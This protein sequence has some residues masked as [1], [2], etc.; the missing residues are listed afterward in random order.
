MKPKGFRLNL[1]KM[2]TSIKTGIIELL[3]KVMDMDNTTFQKNEETLHDCIASILSQVTESDQTMS[4]GW[5]HSYFDQ[6]TLVPDAEFHVPIVATCLKTC[7]AHPL[8]HGWD[9]MFYSMAHFVRK[10]PPST[11]KACKRRIVEGCVSVLCIPDLPQ[12]T[13]CTAIECFSACCIIS[14]DSECPLPALPNISILSKQPQEMIFSQIAKFHVSVVGPLICNLSAQK[15][16]IHNNSI[17]IWLVEYCIACINNQVAVHDALLNLHDCILFGHHSLG[18]RS[19]AIATVI[20]LLQRSVV[21]ARKGDVHISGLIY[22]ILVLVCTVRPSLYMYLLPFMSQ[23]SPSEHQWNC[24]PRSLQW[25]PKLTCDL[26][27]TGSLYH[28]TRIVRQ[29]HSYT[30][31]RN[32]VESKPTLADA[33][34]DLVRSKS[35]LVI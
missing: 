13:Q 4:L 26:C 5:M 18:S 14:Y 15:L 35:D 33:I 19:T 25:R 3:G 22:D 21:D 29:T 28:R 23:L 11:A 30:Y 31:C 34:S 16:D 1:P 7:E 17:W 9:K 24:L 20:V 32:M 10:V 12:T 6:C 2:V 27:G 8:W